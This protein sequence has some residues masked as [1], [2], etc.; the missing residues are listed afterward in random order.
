MEE[1]CM[2]AKDIHY[3]GVNDHRIDLFESQ[4]TVP[5]GVS[6]NSYVITDEKIAVMDTVD[7]AFTHEWLDNLETVLKG[8][9]PDYLVIQHME[10]DHSASIAVFK[11][12]YPDTAIV[13]TSKAFAMMR[14]FFGKDFTENRTVVSDGDTLPLGAHIL[15]FVAAP[16]VHWPEVIVSY[17]ETEKILF[18]A[19]AFG[20]FGALDVKEDWADEARRYYIGIVGKYGRQVQALLKKAA[21]LDMRIICPLHGPVLNENL[22]YYLN[23]YNTWSSYAVEAD[24]IVVAY[25]S[26]Y[27]NTKRAVER[28]ISGLRANG[29]PS[30]AVYD[31]ARCDMSA[32]VADAFRYGKLVLATTT[33]NADIFP[34]MRHFIEALTERN[35]QKRTVALIENGSW[36]PLAAKVMRGMLENSADI[37]FASNTV[38]LLSAPD[39]DSNRQL[40]ALAEE[41]CREYLARQD[42]TANKNDLSALFNLGYG[43]YVVTSNDGKKDNGL[44][45]NTVSQVT[46]MPNRIAVTINKENYSH[47]IIKQTGIMNVNCLS[48]DAPFSVFETF[49]FQ[50]GRTVD[51]FA[52]CEPFR[53]DNGLVFLPKYINS[54]MSLKVMQYVDFDTHGMFICE[55]T[56]ARVISDR[57]TMTYTYYQKHVKPKPQTEGRK[58]YVCKVCGYVYEGEELPE[59]FICPLC[60]HTAADFEPIG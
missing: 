21:A 53:S 15:H 9:R 32:A 28:L 49:G 10:P 50:S 8:R 3:I 57:E 14:Q 26:V 6:Y 30:I 46:N 56:E 52:S 18:S 1:A 42:E 38:K 40:D 23:L 34:P 25:T 47:H 24:G 39:A 37:T 31:L 44:I 45:V 27:G 2:I 58:G 12:N 51:K 29:C 22:G 4:Y 5:N 33:Y 60:K 19:D 48:T 17:E 43:L 11:K 59:D 20:K 35:Y 16:M 55:I 54:F 36:A 7:A 13:A 41:L